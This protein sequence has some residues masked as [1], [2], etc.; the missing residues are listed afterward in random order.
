MKAEQEGWYTDPYGEHEA[1]WLSDGVPTRL[2]RDGKVESFDDPPHAPPSRG[3]V[4]IEPPPGS[5]TAADMLRADAAEAEMTPS[6]AQLN[7]EL[8]S[9][10]LTA[11]A[12]PWFV[13]RDWVPSSTAQKVSPVRRAALIGGGIVAGLTLVLSASLWIALI[14]SEFTSPPTMGGE[15]VLGFVFALAA[16]VGTYLIWRGDRRARVPMAL[17]IQR[18][19][20]AAGLLGLLMLLIYVCAGL[21][22]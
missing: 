18:A 15:I 17:R 13:A 19:E 7:R 10:A 22:A 20:L 6:L 8:N 11:R 21:A 4:A 1:R 9:A 5:A 12:H 16:P 14:V 2:A 3:W